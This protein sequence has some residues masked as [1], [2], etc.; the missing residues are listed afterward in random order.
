MDKNPSRETSIG[1]L[2]H[3]V[4]R[5]FRRRFEDAASPHDITLPQWKVIS[6]LNHQGQLAQV[7]L[8]A[9][10]DS[11]PMTMSKILERLE[12]RGLISREAD[13]A[14][15]RAKVVR[16]TDEGRT[17]FATAKTFGREIY[18]QAL[19]GL[20]GD[21]RAAILAGLVRI[22]DNLNSISAEQKDNQ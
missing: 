13:P 10:V 22:R 8:A 3:E 4:A 16:L 14:D 6:E 21:D 12:K 9:A 18:D 19:E 1:Y 20:S 11:D 7:A 17:L 5:L 2:T 15:S